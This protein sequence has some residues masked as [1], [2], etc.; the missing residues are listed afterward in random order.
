VRDD[1]KGL[2][3]GDLLFGPLDCALYSTDASLFQVTPLGVVAPADEEDLRVLVR[4]AAEHHLPLV[5]R[6]AGTGVAGESLGPGVVV[7]LSRHFREVSDVGTETVR[8]QPGVVLRALNERLAREGRRFA[9]DPTQAHCTLGGMA[10]TDASG[11][12]ALRHGTTRDHV[13]SVR[14]VFADGEVADVG[15][16]PVPPPDRASS[17]EPA[18]TPLRQLV[19]EA[20]GLLEANATLIREHQ[21]RAPFNR[22]GYH[23]D[24]LDGGVLDLPRLLVGSEGTLAFFTELT[25]R[26]VP[27]P[28]GRC[29]LLLGFG[30]LES[31]VRAALAA[32]PTGPAAC[33][34]LDRRVLS[35]ARAQSPDAAR[36]VPSSAEAALLVEFESEDV[37]G[38]LE[39]ARELLDRLRQCGERAALLA[40]PES[41]PAALDRLWA[42]RDAAVPALYGLAGGPRPV[43]VVE[44][45]GVPP[46]ELA[47][48]LVRAQ[49][50]L[51]RHDTTAS[52]L[53]HAL[54][55]Q[56]HTR[57]ILD[58]DDPADAVKLWPIAEEIHGLALDLGGTVSSQ[59]GCGIART[60][61]VSRQYG[62]VYGVF[63]QLKQVFDPRGILNPGKIVG[64][65][66]GGPVWPLRAKVRAAVAVEGEA[67][68]PAGPVR[69]L[70][71][72]VLHL[73][74]EPGE[75]AAQTAACTGCGDCRTES[76]DARMCPTFR[77]THAE[78]ATPRA[79][80]N[81][82]RLL[83]QPDAGPKRAAAEDVRAVAELCVNCRMCARE[84]PSGVDVPRLMLE[85]KAARLAEHGL[86]R[87]D[88]V[89]ARTEGFAALGSRLAPFS[90]LLLRSRWARWWLEKFFGVSRQRKLPPF[91]VFNFS[92]RARLNGWTRRPTFGSRPNVP[93]VGPLPQRAALFV[94][95]FGTHCDPQLPEAAL[96]VLQHHGIEVVV[97]SG[98]RGCGMAALAQG[99]VETA[100]E[101]IQRNLRVF[102]DYARDG[103]FIVC[104]EPTTALLLRQD[105][106]RL[107]DDPDARLVAEHTVE[108]TD[109]LDGL[110]REGR[111]RTDFR[112]LGLRVGHHV[113]CHRKALGGEPAGPGLLSLIPG[114]RVSTIDVGCSGMAGTFGLKAQNYNA[115]HEIG[116]PVFEA[117][118]AAGATHGS[119]ECSSCRLQLEDGAG[120]RTLHPVQYLA[121]AYGLMPE[122]AARLHE[123]IR[124]L[125]TR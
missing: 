11:A 82:M 85:A 7:D 22:C 12:R 69:P 31:A 40:G 4:Y 55:G 19:R 104:P 59:H 56:V 52:F 9:P 38:A 121:L 86:D 112:P 101:A 64:P 51:R 17:G 124:E 42:V 92:L 10:A 76:P 67:P 5:P 60:P 36:V 8:V 57:P 114:V 62:P 39:R 14:T 25:L 71:L 106:P 84:C 21:P 72:P 35:L 73:H 53:V 119:T 13:A 74:W 44:D 90:N 43:A 122:L 50:V 18:D 27:I 108:L 96:R 24:A 78:A 105:A 109:F 49:E 28:A 123:P 45:V 33:E 61:W 97:P 6:G 30:G 75:L 63:R 16:E 29:G 94:D 54:A 83:L 116:R 15:R 99:D 2:L 68:A 23:L 110:R 20:A 120:T 34:L 47:T 32:R 115:S 87:A 58:P 80:A 26:T 117:I 3:R 77:V 98:Q 79:K 118:H 46:E 48:F 100:R 81:L 70:E 1:L 95:V 65:A 107:V 37:G 66:P 93:D 91:A 113:P 103:Y 88:W 125:V 102:A 89:M 111:L 41:D